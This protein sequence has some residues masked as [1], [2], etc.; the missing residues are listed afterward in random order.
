MRYD[1][2]VIGGSLGGVMAAYQAARAG[3]KVLLVSEFDW[4]GGQ[5]TT[6]G[7]PPDEHRLIESGGA[8][9]SYLGFRDAMRQ[10]YLRDPEFRDNSVLTE[11]CNPGDGWVSRLCFEP[12]YAATYFD[13]LLK[14]HVRAGNLIILRGTLA[15][16]R[17]RGR[18][19][20]RVTV[21]TKQDTVE[22]VANYFLDATDTGALIKAAGLSYR[23]G[24]EAQREFDEADAPREANLLDQQPVTFVMALR[25][26][27]RKALPDAE[28][29][30]P[31]E[32]AFWKA[33][34]VPHFNYPQFSRHLPGAKR[35]EIAELPLFAEGKTLDWWRYRR[36]VSSNNWVAP[37]NEVSL[38]N[39]A[40]NDFALQPL[41]DGPMPEA[42]VVKAAKSLSRC[43]L[44]WLQTEAPREGS[45]N[46]GY[47][48]YPELE[49]APDVLGTSDGFAQQVYVRESRRIRGIDCLAAPAITADPSMPLLPTLVG[50]SVG[51]GW[52]NVDIHPTV[53]SGHTVNTK[54]RPFALPLGVFIHVDCDNLIPACKNISVTHLVNA[55]TRVHPVEWIVGEIAGVLAEFAVSNGLALAEIHAHD[56]RV[57]A[58]QSRLKDAGIPISWSDDLIGKMNPEK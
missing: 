32:Y 26:T 30:P 3:R 51:I 21:Q 14:P 57:S 31:P 38:I 18:V 56:Y 27:G 9:T 45:G 1:I 20:E 36:I 8:S 24:K 33:R 10:R 19:I 37:R 28:L 17:R 46:E 53:I 15:R 5:M 34:I 40:Q 22:I 54:V 4:L 2:A 7:V 52:Y 47:I 42:D 50:D 55:A 12:I 49:L 43:F 25:N 6:Q 29:Q 23:L 11:G 39:W 48:G 41:L 13:S 58:L 35:G 44:H 16:A